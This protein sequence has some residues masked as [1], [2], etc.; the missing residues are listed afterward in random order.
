MGGKQVSRK[1]G[2]WSQ[3]RQTKVE[4]E[5]TL[6]TVVRKKV[7]IPLGPV[8]RQPDLRPQ[9]HLQGGLVEDLFA[10]LH[11]GWSVYARQDRCIPWGDS[12]GGLAHI[13]PSSGVPVRR[14]E[15]AGQGP[16]RHPPVQPTKCW[17]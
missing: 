14:A 8:T 16:P 17:H 13:P 6:G 4:A 12:A 3:E 5:G 2:R 9:N 10:D 7:E 1:K 11:L 15:P